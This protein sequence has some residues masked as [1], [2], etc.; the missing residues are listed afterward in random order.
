MTQVPSFASYVGRHGPLASRSILSGPEQ[1]CNGSARNT[2]L[3]Q[4]PYARGRMRRLGAPSPDEIDLMMRDT[5][6]LVNME[7]L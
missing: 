3:E 6:L 4:R 5:G 1:R 2:A 7:G